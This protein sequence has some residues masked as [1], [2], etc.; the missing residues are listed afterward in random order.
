MKKQVEKSHYYDA[1]YDRKERFMGYWYQI[2]ELNKFRSSDILEIGI[3][4][5][6]VSRYLKERGVR[7]TGLDF[8][9]DLAP[10]VVGD[11]RCLPFA[12]ASF[13]VVAC[14][15]VLEHLPYENFEMA[16]AEIHRVTKSHAILSI[17]DADIVY[18]FY[19]HVIGLGAIKKLIPLP[20]LRRRRHV[21]NGQHY[22][23]IGKAGYPLKRIIRDIE[24]SGFTVE[25]TYRAF[26]QPYHR[27]FNL[28][29]SM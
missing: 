9:R 14:Y 6:F 22:W 19:F 4:N 8:D 25:R 17:P 18:Q 26:E 13:D 3:G 29:K 11:A 12:A 15:E 10:D 20:R 2:H 5:K 28:I 16:L 7:I 1:R 27:F 21:F 24:K 23:E